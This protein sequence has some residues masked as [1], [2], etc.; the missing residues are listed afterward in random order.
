MAQT[1]QDQQIDMALMLRRLQVNQQVYAQLG[2]VVAHGPFKGMAISEQS[3]WGNDKAAKLLGLYEQQ[4]AQA[5][6]SACRPNTVFVDLGAADGYY[7]VGLTHARLV[8]R[9][10]AYEMTEQGRR[11]TT[12]NAQRSGVADR[13][14]VRG[15]CDA[16][17]GAQLLAEFGTLERLV[18]LCDIEGAEFEVFDEANLQALREATVFIEIHDFDAAGRQGYA[19]LLERAAR[20]FEVQVLGNG[21]RD[22][23]AFAELRMFNDTDRWLACSEGRGPDAKWLRLSPRLRPHQTPAQRTLILTTPN[24]FFMVKLLRTIQTDVHEPLAIDLLRYGQRATLGGVDA[25]VDADALPPGVRQFW[26]D[27]GRVPAEADFANLV[28]QADGGEAAQPL[29]Q[30]LS[31]YEN[32]AVY[33]INAVHG[34]LLPWL[35]ET[36]GAQRLSVLCSDNEIDLRHRAMAVR[37]QRGGPLT[38]AERTSFPE[39]VER[40]FEAVDRFVVPRQPWQDMLALERQSPFEVDPY[41]IPIKN[42]L[43][44]LTP[45]RA[46]DGSYQLMLHAK[47][48]LPREEFARQ[49]QQV[50]AAWRH[51]RPLRLLTLRNDINSGWVDL[52]EGRGRCLLTVHPYPMPER[53]YLELL[54][55]CDGL[56]IVPRGGLVTIRDAARVGLDLV[57]LD[58]GFN[59]NLQTLRDEI[60]LVVA[61]ADDL[62]T[63]HQGR[64]QA[65]AVR[66]QNGRRLAQYENRCIQWF[67]QRYA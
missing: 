64:L 19:R 21:P 36:F 57:N 43:R 32:I 5:L 14:T 59:P 30:L 2:G 61:G 12:E 11:V 17:L 29:Q 8:E 51:D 67:R 10:I 54:L 60:G 26:V 50:L 38:V 47:P 4:L 1:A 44:G 7:A 37:R 9:C 33:S 24:D 34:P 25:C 58:E 16:G 53:H 42:E 39:S 22:P 18:V 56:A 40:A 3:S 65:A 35:R 41:L 49:L 20:H 52:P 27:P 23:G 13:L 6:V 63:L 48:S 31:G 62:A 55:G 28:V 46:A 15:A 45:V 66:Q